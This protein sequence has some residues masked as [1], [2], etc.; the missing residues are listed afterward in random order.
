[1]SVRIDKPLELF[2]QLPGRGAVERR[3]V[4]VELAELDMGGADVPHPLDHPA[5]Q[6]HR[7][8]PGLGVGGQRGEPLAVGLAGMGQPVVGGPIG[9]VD[10]G[11]DAVGVPQDQEVVPDPEVVLGD[12]VGVLGP[13]SCRVR[14][15]TGA[16]DNGNS[17][18]L[19][20]CCSARCSGPVGR[21]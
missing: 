3:A 12:D 18:L 21:A 4:G 14:S 9:P 2:E 7:G 16:T 11:F 6:V 20:T 17:A 5:P 15:A 19:G 13:E 10:Q 1:M 8:G